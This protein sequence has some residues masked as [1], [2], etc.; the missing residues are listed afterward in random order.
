MLCSILI[1][2]PVFLA[3]VERI[4]TI[5]NRTGATRELVP[6]FDTSL[7][8]H[9]DGSREKPDVLYW[10]RNSSR[11]IRF[12]T[13][14]LINTRVHSSREKSR[15]PMNSEQ[16]RAELPAFQHLL[17]IG[18]TETGK[19]AGYESFG[20]E[21]LPY[22]ALWRATFWWSDPGKARGVILS[23]FATHRCIY[24]GDLVEMGDLSENF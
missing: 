21:T 20:W 11:H 4:E 7:V 23:S 12:S 19:L 8:N 2:N 9:G 6:V 16:P 22:I 18:C 5:E 15:A 17:S 13:V 3:M 24:R 10:S 1:E 14:N